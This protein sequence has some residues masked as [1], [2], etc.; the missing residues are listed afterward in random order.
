MPK[1]PILL[2]A[3]LAAALAGSAAGAGG[4]TLVKTGKTGL[5]RILVDSHGRSLYL[6]EADK[7]TRSACYG[8]CA[9]FWPPLLTTVKPVAGAGAAASLLGTTK[10]RDGKL[11][12]TYH[13]HPLYLF[14]Q[15]TRAGMTKGQDSHAFGAGWYAL[16][17]GGVKVAHE[18]ERSTTP[19]STTPT[20]TYTT[21]DPIPGY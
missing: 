14:V 9:R 19:T 11:Q 3:L 15:D 21:T 16:T 13:G 17:P 18:T 12:V 10:R 5:G 20:P 4:G 8:A 6:F 2:I 7:G 1:T